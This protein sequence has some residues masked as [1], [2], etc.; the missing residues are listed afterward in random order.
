MK[1]AVIGIGQMGKRHA[2]LV[3]NFDRCQLVGLCD[4]NYEAQQQLDGFNVPFYDSTKELLS[5]VQ[6]DGVII[7][8]PSDTHLEIMELC[9]AYG[10]HALIEK[11]IANTNDA[12]ERIVA[13]TES[14]DS[15]VLVGHHRRYNPLIQRLHSIVS[16][17]GIGK[18]VAVS[19]IWGLM[20]PEDYFSQQW[21]VTRP[22]GGPVL[23]NLIHELDLLRY[24]CGEID[25]IGAVTSSN[26]R[27]YEVE[28][29]VAISMKFENGA[30]G[31]LIGS[32]TVTSPWSYETTTEENPM[33][34]HV[35]ENCY[36]FMG[37]LGSIGFP[38]ME[39]W[40][41]DDPHRMG[42]QHSLTKRLLK[43]DLEDPLMIQLNHF[44]D[45]ISGLSEPLIDA[46]DASKSLALAL[47]VLN[48][49][50]N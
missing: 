27:G 37:D 2:K 18:L 19:A 31:T 11:P 6:P 4:A 26:T 3:S 8:T 22:D 24:L 12:A 10:I 48:S 29:S 39:L 30:I 9:A 14:S 21:R 13:L 41:Y 32:D 50:E 23:I 7:A 34:H 42:W 43:V 35:S 45:V 40:Q 16:N 47:S 15:K 46:S 44:C 20:K 1:I 49:G 25:T 5:S 17:K 38:K 33:Y 36:Y 28:D